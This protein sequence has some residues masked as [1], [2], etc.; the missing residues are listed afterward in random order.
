[1]IRALEMGVMASGI[2]DRVGP[3]D[4]VV[5]ESPPVLVT[6]D[7]VLTPEE[8][9]R[10]NPSRATLNRIEILVVCDPFE[11]RDVCGEGCVS[12]FCEG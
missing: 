9:Q 6:G 1:M 8:V 2:E 5:T 10:R 7:M 12:F 3:P 4:I 11:C